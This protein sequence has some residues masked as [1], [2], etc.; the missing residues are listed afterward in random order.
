MAL[1]LTLDA[2]HQLLTE[3][4]FWRRITSDPLARQGQ[5]SGVD[6]PKAVWVTPQLPTFMLQPLQLRQ[7][8]LNTTNQLDSILRLSQFVVN[9]TDAANLSIYEH[10]AQ[11]NL[12][13][14]YIWHVP[15]G[16]SGSFPGMALPPGEVPGSPP[17]V[18]GV[19]YPASFTDIDSLTAV[20]HTVYQMPATLPAPPPAAP[21]TPTVLGGTADGRFL[22]HTK[23][24][25]A[26]NQGLLLRW[27]H[28]Q[29]LLGFPSVYCFFIGQ[30]ALV[31]KNYGLEMYR[32]VSPGGDRTAWKKVKSAPLYGERGGLDTPGGSFA[33]FG[34]YE[35]Y[36]KT[37]PGDSTAGERSLLWLPFRRNQVLLYAGPTGRSS[38]FQV[39]ARPVRLPDN[40]DWAIVRSDVL[41]V[42]ALT[43]VPG[44]FQ[45]QKLKYVTGDV[46]VH[47]P[48]FTLDYTPT[49]P[50]TI[51]LDGDHDRATGLS[52][53]LS[54]P[55]S[56]TLPTND[57]SDCPS[58]TTG[59][60]DQSRT[61][62]VD[63]TLAA[64]SDG[65]WSPALYAF[66]AAADPKFAAATTTPHDVTDKNPGAVLTSLRLSCGQEPGEGRA[67]VEVWDPQPYALSAWYYRTGLPVQVKQGTTALFTGTAEPQELI[68]PRI[69]QSPAVATDV[70]RRL[71][72]Q[73]V[74]YW[75]QL[76][77]TYPRNRQ[78]WTGTGHITCVLQNAKQAGI[79]VTGADTPPINTP[80]LAAQWDTPLGGPPEEKSTA[81]MAH[82]LQGGWTPQQKESVGDFVQ[83]IARW[84]SG[85]EVGFYPDGKLFYR[86]RDFYTAVEATFYRNAAEASGDGQPS[87]P[88]LRGPVSFVTE[89]PEANVV[90]VFG[91]DAQSGQPARSPVFVDW[92]S[93][94]NPAKV[95]YLGRW[96]PLPVQAVGVY[97][98]KQLTWMARKVW[99][100]TR[101]R[102]LAAQFTADFVPALR[103]G[104]VCRL[105]L[106]ASGYGNYRVRS[107]E[108]EMTDLHWHAC[109]YEAVLL[110]TGF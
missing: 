58:A 62:G 110:E 61:Y 101:R 104:H 40:S 57:A 83:R 19:P 93:I 5:P 76:K 35:P 64:S 80:A 47:A 10:A 97:T 48:T 21:P 105:A 71:P 74:D 36:W 1:T 90:A 98:C 85:W 28:P 67:R 107:Y 17:S 41:V 22:V 96:K 4:G 55:P 106:G 72:Y 51:T 86:P 37:G 16:P 45:V 79:D 11:A 8:W 52:A 20:P 56:Y 82:D 78:D 60:S 84:F 44:R 75:R 42:W 69:A 108:V 102:V 66:T 32:D 91:T 92:A 18:I 89:E 70:P 59:S 100:R 88:L 7:D 14:P 94:R 25:L 53:A 13:N 63:V 31:L 77:E 109:R 43:P 2:P 34:L 9:A 46:V 24:R 87:A 12:A 54:Q 29:D 30:F 49:N 50:V 103:V 68:V 38:V 99:D 3:P 65:R 15:V 27:F 33:P 6:A 39:N 95:N 23:D 26:D 73:A 81:Q